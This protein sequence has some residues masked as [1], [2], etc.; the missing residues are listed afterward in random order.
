MKVVVFAGERKRGQVRG[1]GLLPF[2]GNEKQRTR[3]GNER[4]KQARRSTQQ[5]KQ[6]TVHDITCDAPFDCSVSSQT[7]LVPAPAEE[8]AFDMGP[9][10]PGFKWVVGIDMELVQC[11]TLVRT[12]L[13]RIGPVVLHPE[14]KARAIC[15]PLPSSRVVFR[16]GV[17][18]TWVTINLRNQLLHI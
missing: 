1:L 15:T 5:P 13:E 9:H 10:L 16:V 8:I 14:V 12:F 11:A 3:D 18:H 6:T 7:S 4:S 17:H 2:V